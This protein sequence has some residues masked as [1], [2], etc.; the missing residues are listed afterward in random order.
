MSDMKSKPSAY[1]SPAC[2][3]HEMDA[4]YAGYYGKDDLVA[5]L[6]LLLEAERAG[7][8]LLSEFLAAG[9]AEEARPL[10]QAIRHDEA[11][12]AAMLSQAVRALDGEPSK[13]T[14]AF[15]EKCLAIEGFAERLAFLN[16]GQG[17]VARKL[18]EALPRI[19]GDALHRRLKEML[20]VHEANIRRCA[21]HLQG[22]A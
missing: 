15:Y 18:A 2:H 9:P 20:E 14:G 4:A 22:R 7:A 3:A 5:L 6:N 21:E 16:R 13:A 11:R 8:R 17:W 12:F 19:G 10:L 1:S